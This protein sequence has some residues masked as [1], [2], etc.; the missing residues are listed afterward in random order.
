MSST[1]SNDNLSH[2]VDGIDDLKDLIQRAHATPW[3]KTCSALWAQAA[4]LAESQGKLDQAVKC[5]S[6][7]CASYAM[8]GELT[9]V[10]GPISWLEQHYKTNPEL[11]DD[12]EVHALG[13]YYKYSIGAAKGL[14]KVSV[15][16]CEQLLAKM[17]EHY[18]QLSESLRPW[19]FRNYSFYYELGQEDLA[20]E[21]FWQWYSAPTS[22]LSDCARCEPGNEVFFYSNKKQWE[23]AVA[24]G[25]KGL[26]ITADYCDSQPEDLLANMMLP[27]L[28]TGQ[29]DKAWAAHLR[30]YRRYQQSPRYFEMLDSQICYLALSG[31]LD[32][33]E[34]LDR[35]LGILL[36][37]LP[38]MK[39][40]ESPR[41]LLNFAQTAVLLLDSFSESRLAEMVQVNLPGDS[42]GWVEHETVTDPTLAAMRGWFYQLAVKL[43]D[44]FDTRPGH[45]NPGIERI[46]LA[47]A[48]N[49]VLPPPLPKETLRN[50][51]GINDEDV[52]AVYNMGQ[53]ARRSAKRARQEES[54]EENYADLP[55]VD[56]NGEWSTMSLGEL[57]IK[58]S[59]FGLCGLSTAYGMQATELIMA[60]PQLL[61]TF[62]Q[63][64]TEQMQPAWEWISEEAKLWLG[65]LEDVNP[66]YAADCSDEAFGLLAEAS[67][68]LTKKQWVQAAQ[69]ADEAVSAKSAEPLGAR[70]AALNILS[71]T[72]EKANYV[73]EAVEPS[74]LM[75]NL[76]AAAGFGFRQ[77][78]LAT[79]LA[80]ILITLERN[81]EAIEVA[82]NGLDKLTRYPVAGN[83]ELLLNNII[84]A[85]S[86]K[87]NYPLVAGRYYAICAQSV[88]A[89]DSDRQSY[90]VNAG[91]HFCLAQDVVQGIASYQ[92]AVDMKLAELDTRWESF[93]QLNDESK[94]DTSISKEQI[95]YVLLGYKE[96]LFESLSLI[97]EFCEAIVAQPGRV[98][99][100]DIEMMER[101]M[102]ILRE[103]SCSEQNDSLFEKSNA[104]RYAD[105]LSDYG[106]MNWMCY[107]YRDAFDYTEMAAEKFAELGDD[108]R[109]LMVKCNIC[110]MYI[111]LGETEQAKSLADELKDQIANPK[112]AGSDVRKK[113]KMIQHRLD[114]IG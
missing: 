47:E 91:R 86:S 114:E 89:D 92:Q 87:L 31:R 69:L 3:G 99:E 17:K 13:W 62:P 72:A 15:A 1:E 112:L 19:Y 85:A 24:A 107:R 7:L 98:P 16:Q 33:P 23:Q 25:E 53:V 48:L 32:R 2:I 96:C 65:V 56:L 36:R 80:S 28:Y 43:A 35:G 79:R 11:F 71:W 101:Y 51:T 97:Y 100:A 103:R 41:I 102:G 83:Y 93:N 39:E 95:Q 75:V 66:E 21:N 10:F 73:A 68:F 60:D 45:P 54:D 63:Q 70:I 74:K 76:A 4:K 110:Q 82:Q 52:L 37:H 106:Y 26:A 14:P 84:A 81:E 77:A 38:W 49:P 67:R 22:E 64:L 78:R 57:L 46:R 18:L 94:N 88:Y 50:V 34:R 61:D 6:S 9:R 40:A 113:F 20:E 104:W 8:G 27:W 5:Y 109:A 90:L 58:E 44:D 105:W 108:E 29:D 12:E 42:L 55:P 111:A 59:Q 30:A